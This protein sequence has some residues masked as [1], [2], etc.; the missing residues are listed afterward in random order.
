[1]RFTIT[2]NNAICLWKKTTVDFIRMLYLS[3]GSVCELETRILLAGALTMKKIDCCNGKYHVLVDG[4]FYCMKPLGVEC[5]QSLKDLGK[6]TKG[7]KKILYCQHHQKPCTQC[8][9]HKVNTDMPED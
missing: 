1:V 3:C 7:K 5:S 8:K 6:F 2:L 9:M 4:K